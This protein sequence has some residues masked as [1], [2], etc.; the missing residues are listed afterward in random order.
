M[1]KIKVEKKSDSYE[2]GSLFEYYGDIYI[3]AATGIYEFNLIRLKD[4]ARFTNAVSYG[5][6]CF[7]TKKELHLLYNDPKQLLKFIC[8]PS[9]VVIEND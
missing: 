3:L 7:V 5:D 9:E 8:G 1:I 6:D 4:G 2:F